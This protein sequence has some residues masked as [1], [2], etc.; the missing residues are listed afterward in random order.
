LLIGGNGRQLLSL[1]ACEADIVGLAGITFREGAGPP[2]LSGWRTAAVDERI[3]LIRK[4]AG[5]E[6]FAQLEIEALVQRVIVT[7]DRSRAAAEL[8]T[9]WPQLSAD[10]VLNAPYVL[11]GTAEQI[12][13]DLNAHRE[14][15]GISS[16]NVQ[17]AYVEA[18]AP[19]VA[20]LAGK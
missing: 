9:G 12:V 15:W 8:A 1:A 7:D 18:F 11:I 20:R 19:I 16:Y 2:D 4:A 13:A 17:E 14:R 5:E 3:S 10:E 6:R